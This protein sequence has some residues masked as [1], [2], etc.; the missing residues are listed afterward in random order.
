MPLSASLV[1]LLHY[2]IIKG[3]DILVKPEIVNRICEIRF[4]YPK[5]LH[6]FML[7]SIRI[8]CKLYCHIPVNLTFI[9]KL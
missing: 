4:I 9:V 5:K 7:H 3:L 6:N 8:L 1:F 2:Y